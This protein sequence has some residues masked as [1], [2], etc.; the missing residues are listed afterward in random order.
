MRQ[1]RVNAK[2]ALGTLA[3]AL[4]LPVIAQESPESLLPPGFG[5][6]PPAPPASAPQPARPATPGAPVPMVQPLP[7]SSDVPSA[8]NALAGEAVDELSEEELAAQKQKY[9]LPPGA[10]RSLDRVGPLTPAR[11]GLEP[12][13]FG[14]QSGLFLATLMKET[15]APVT[16]RWASILLRRALLSATDTPRDI[17]G[18]DWVAERAWLLLRMGEADSAR[19]LVQSVDSDKFTPRLYAVA[20]QTYLAT[21]DPAGLCPLSTGALRYS[22]EP[23]WDMTRAICPA[24][25]G[26]QGSASAALNQAQR[27]GVVR[28]VDYRLAEKVVGTGFNARRS[29]K[30]EWDGVDGLTAWRF[31]LATALNVEIPDALY[32]TAG[33]HVRAWEARAPALSAVRRLPGSEA[34]ARLGV[35]SNQALVGF[36]SQLAADG[37]ATP[38]IADKVDALRNAYRASSPGERVQ[39]MRTLWRDNGKPDYVGLIATAKAAAALPVTTIDAREAAN[40]VASMLTAGYDRSAARWS[41]VARQAEGD[42]AGDLWALL[43]VGA[44][45]AVVDISEGRVSSFADEAGAAKGQMLIAALAGLARLNPQASASLAQ[46]NGLNLA[47]NSR[48]ARAIHQA[49]GRGEKATVAL[50]AAVGMQAAEWDRLPAAHLYHI[51]AALHQ[52]G[53]DPEARMIAAEAITRI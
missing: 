43:A 12:D 4:A 5:E 27:R 21:A 53:L 7:P 9:D 31:G 29:V 46:D 23:G 15:R 26:D 52:V 3:F 18:A 25:S 35:F 33:R 37:D 39:G 6:A 8:D 14:G 50:L 51:V 34:A 42:G 49:A 17:N 10:Q 16:S 28:G 48:W 22:K 47:V 1:S 40:L 32:A 20:M 41:G 24:L 38:E 19:L 36:Y 13:A 11:L 2:W 45:S 30:I 44:P